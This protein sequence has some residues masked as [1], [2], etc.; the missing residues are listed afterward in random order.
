MR[1]AAFAFVAVLLTAGAMSVRAA[2]SVIQPSYDALM[3][4]SA[5]QR[6]QALK[7]MDI[8]T[9]LALSRTH[10]D[11]WLAENR[12]RL[13]ENQLAIVEEVRDNLTPEL[14]RSERLGV[15]ERQM[16]CELWMSD[17]FALTLARADRPSSRFDD[18]RY[19]LRSCVLEDVIEFIY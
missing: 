3:A 10:I 19:W 5:E 14:Y 18:V 17:V 4:M 2:D 12:P 8:P 7:A 13:S 6:Q 11:R 1:T 15:L 16:Q 9:H